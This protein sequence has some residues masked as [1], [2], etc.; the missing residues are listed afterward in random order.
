MVHLKS[1]GLFH[2][3]SDETTD[4]AGLFAYII[5]TVNINFPIRRKNTLDKFSSR[6][7][8]KMYDVQG[9][10]FIGERYNFLLRMTAD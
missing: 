10:K 8:P 6:I 3:Q 7:S 9:Y 2:H 5:C 1:P 4:P